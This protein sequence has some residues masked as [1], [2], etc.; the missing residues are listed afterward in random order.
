MCDKSYDSSD[1]NFLIP[2]LQTLSTQGS[3]EVRLDQNDLLNHIRECDDCL[4]V[5]KILICIE[6]ENGQQAYYLALAKKV[7]CLN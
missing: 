1:I 3:V 5:L 4:Y 6:W 2:C 7:F